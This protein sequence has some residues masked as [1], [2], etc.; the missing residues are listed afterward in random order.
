MINYFISLQGGGPGL[1]YMVPQAISLKSQFLY[2]YHSWLLHCNMTVFCTAVSQ[3]FIIPIHA[4]HENTKQP[5]TEKISGH[6]F[7]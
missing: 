5:T 4:M 3:I 2:F 1:L 6:E 7:D